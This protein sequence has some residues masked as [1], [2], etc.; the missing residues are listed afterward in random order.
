MS[1]SNYYFNI[2]QLRKIY[3]RAAR[4]TSN[5]RNL[6]VTITP[7]TC[8]MMDNAVGLGNGKYGSSIFELAVRLLLCL[9][10]EGEDL[11][12]IVVE[13]KQATSSPYLVRNLTR[14]IRYLETE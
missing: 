13:I 7:E 5:R 2:D 12:S 1:T 3:G 10:T 11:S 9:V 4:G 6:K 8:Q 14:L